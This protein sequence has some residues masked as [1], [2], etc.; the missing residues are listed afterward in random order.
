MFKKDLAL[1]NLQWL[2]C[3]KIKQNQS[4]KP[5]YVN[6]ANEKWTTQI[7][8]Y[9]QWYHDCCY[10]KVGYL[11]WYRPK[12]Q[13]FFLQLVKM[14]DLGYWLCEKKL[15][16]AE[17]LLYPTVLLEINSKHYFSP[18][19]QLNIKLSYIQTHEEYSLL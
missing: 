12:I 8:F 7:T 13:V 15:L 17:N 5:I 3:H 2:I 10:G 19:Q 11:C 14:H 16:V 4:I 6:E 18:P 9:W 1:N